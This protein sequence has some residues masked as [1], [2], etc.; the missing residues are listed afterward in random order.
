MNLAYKLGDRWTAEGWQTPSKGPELQR[1]YDAFAVAD[2]LKV[3]FVGEVIIDEYRYVRALQKSAKEYVIATAETGRV[4]FA[5][6]IIAAAKQAE[7]QDVDHISSWKNIR[8]TRYVDHDFKR[9]LFEVYST[10]AIR[11]TEEERAYFRRQ[12]QEAVDEADV[13]IV[14][15]FGHGLIGEA[16][17]VILANAKFLAVNA[18]SNA[19]NYGY[20][21]VTKYQ[22]ADLVCID[23]PEARLAT[24]MQHEPDIRA[25]IV[26]MQ[27]DIMCRHFIVTRGRNGICSCVFLPDS[28]GVS[29]GGYAELPAFA[30]GGVDTIGAG[31][32]VIAV[33]APL[34]AAGLDLETATMVGNVAGAIKV[35]IVGHERHVGRQELMDA[36]EARL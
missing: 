21:P 28:D 36:I 17:R 30:P 25:V 13:V 16:E 3:R 1:I 32:A 4:E 26:D 15:D 12:V 31:D 18:Q 27:R 33:A 23:E 35:G 22:E 34:I 10:D 19:G 14:L 24:H 9:K 20:N 8:K 2:K 6:G 7:W 11:L 5:G 29:V